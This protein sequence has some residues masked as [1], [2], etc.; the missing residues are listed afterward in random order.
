MP[1][2]QKK[3]R[4]RDLSYQPVRLIPVMTS[5]KLEE[6]TPEKQHFT[7]HGFTLR[8][9]SP[10][11]I[12]TQEVETSPPQ[13]ASLIEVDTQAPT[14]S[15]RVRLINGNQVTVSV[16]HTH[17]VQQLIDHVRVLSNTSGTFKL[18]DTTIIPRKQLT[19]GSV[20]IK[21]A[22]LL[23]GTILQIQ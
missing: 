22:N 14:T 20:T 12:P 10:Q 23:N 19:D 17:T 16:N 9:F 21:Q 2:R 6:K 7:G 8:S 13:S 15:L 1:D 18:M 3:K 11:N 4:L 5:Q